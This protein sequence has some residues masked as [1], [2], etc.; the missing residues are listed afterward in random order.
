MTEVLKLLGY[1]GEQ[2]RALSDALQAI[3][4][5]ETDSGNDMMTIADL[6]GRVKY[7][8]DTRTYMTSPAAWV[9]TCSALLII[10]GTFLIVAYK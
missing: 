7:L 10:A 5:Y 6:R 8:E 1:I 4:K 3:K 9:G 2:S